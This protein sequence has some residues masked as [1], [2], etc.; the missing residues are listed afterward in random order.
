MVEFLLQIVVL[1]VDGGQLGLD[2]SLGGWITQNVTKGG[3]CSFQICQQ[4]ALTFQL[5]FEVLEKK[6]GTFMNRLKKFFI[7]RLVLLL[8]Q[9]LILQSGKRRCVNLLDVLVTFSMST[10]CGSCKDMNISS[11]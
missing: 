3:T 4:R 2:F 1:S 6:T 11:L 9:C 10:V 5:A 7:Q 8:L